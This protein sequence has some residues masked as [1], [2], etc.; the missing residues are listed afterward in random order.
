MVDKTRTRGRARTREEER[1]RSRSRSRTPSRSRSRSR[2][3]AGSRKRRYLRKKS[4]TRIHLTKG[5][6][7]RYGYSSVKSMSAKDRRKILE[8][9]LRNEDAL[10]VFRKLNALYVLNK[11]NNPES[12]AVFMADRNWVR[13]NY[14][15]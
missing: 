3:S 7:S 5:S 11:N 2:D 13:D 12:S 1:P 10:A 4:P 6:L 14:D 9:V 8:R 15:I